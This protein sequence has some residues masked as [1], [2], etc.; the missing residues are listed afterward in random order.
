MSHDLKKTLL[1]ICVL[2]F[3]SWFQAGIASAQV[4]S[5]DE[6][7]T[8]TQKYIK[9]LTEKGEKVHVN[10]AQRI[11]KYLTEA[12]EAARGMYLAYKKEWDKLLGWEETKSQKD[13]KALQE[14]LALAE[15]MTS[16]TDS[17]S[18][19]PYELE[20]RRLE[21]EATYHLNTH[22]KT[23]TD[24]TCEPA[25]TVRATA[26][27][28]VVAA[29]NQAMT[30]E[31]ITFEVIQDLVIDGEREELYS[32]HVKLDTW[33]PQLAKEK[34]LHW[35]DLLQKEGGLKTWATKLNEVKCVP[36]SKKHG[37]KMDL[38]LLKFL[39]GAKDESVIRCEFLKA[40]SQWEK[41][42][43]KPYWQMSIMW[44][45]RW[46]VLKTYAIDSP[47]KTTLVH[48]NWKAADVAAEIQKK[49]AATN[50]KYPGNWVR[51]QIEYIYPWILE[52]K[53]EGGKKVPVWRYPAKAETSFFVKW[54]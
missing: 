26:L 41:Y 17:K 9:A 18:F 47:Y 49:A 23:A 20:W 54:R 25:K 37:D 11:L 3:T 29:W 19:I 38:S 53:W 34:T 22:C 7:R 52:W 45:G 50:F 12:P 24:A 15:K 1:L 21:G 44:A 51:V 46:E 36:V 2:V 33:I 28:K 32:P 30:T 40:P 14:K 43:K 5:D 16:P 42:E 39:Y 35:K 13:L 31:A 48:W 4:P 8:N 6:I 27:A 10:N